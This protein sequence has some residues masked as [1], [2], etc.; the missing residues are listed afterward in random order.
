MSKGKNNYWPKGAPLKEVC[1]A[2]LV[3]IVLWSHG[4]VGQNHGLFLKALA[5]LSG[6]VAPPPWLQWL[7]PLSTSLQSVTPLTFITSY[8]QFGIYCFTEVKK[9]WP[10]FKPGCFYHS[11]DAEGFSGPQGRTGDFSR[12]REISVCYWIWGYLCNYLVIHLWVHMGLGIL[13]MTISCTETPLGYS[14]SGTRCA[15]RGKSDSSQVQ[16]QGFYSLDKICP[17]HSHS[18]N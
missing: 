12:L 6:W 13:D 4:G 15:I 18:F 2:S 9:G 5:L 3:C 14:S 1:V 7:L 17:K 11:F 8:L 16:K 10:L